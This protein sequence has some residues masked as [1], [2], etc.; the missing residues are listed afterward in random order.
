VVASRFPEAEVTGVDLAPEMV[1]E[2]QALLPEE[3]AG[4]VRFQVGDG[5]A[6]PFAEGQFDLVVL[7][8]M[9]PFVSEV[10][11][12][13]AP[14]GHVLIAFSRGSD[15]PIWAPAETLRPLL[16]RAGFERVREL[17]AGSGSALL[18]AKAHPG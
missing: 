8:N 12:V 16:A 6:L 15:T 4:R 11:R 13:T 3:L 5:S 9:I 1:R 17:Q 10:G 18:A 14:G 7:Q 2:A